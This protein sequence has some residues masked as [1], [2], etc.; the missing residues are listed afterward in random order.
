LD[1]TP[2]AL[3]DALHPYVTGS[4]WI[5]KMNFPD[6][7]VRMNAASSETPAHVKALMNAQSDENIIAIWRKYK[8]N[9]MIEWK[10]S[11]KKVVAAH[12][13]V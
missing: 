7:R 13:L 11:I 8:D 6:R 10:E 4:I 5:G 2:D 1:E 3:Y 12:N 9:P